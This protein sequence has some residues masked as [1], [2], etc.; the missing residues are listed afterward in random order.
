MRQLGH[1]E[2]KNYLPKREILVIT[3]GIMDHRNL[4]QLFRLADGFGVQAIYLDVDIDP[5][6]WKLE[7]ISRSTINH[8]PFHDYSDVHLLATQ[9]HD[10]GYFLIALEKCDQSKS[11][12]DLNV[13][14]YKRLA[15]IIGNE[16]DGISSSWL[17]ESDQSMHIPM[18]GVNTSFNVV[19]ALGIGLYELRRT[20]MKDK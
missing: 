9:L 4:G 6:K 10:E 12:V 3:D 8:I 7:R 18:F 19:H 1:S 17:K 13:S 5:M 14:K 20:E 11:I 2:I 16:Q 15:V